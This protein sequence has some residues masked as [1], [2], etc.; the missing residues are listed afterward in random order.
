MDNLVKQRIG[1]FDH[2]QIITTKNVTY[3]SAAPGTEI[4]PVGLWS[5]AAVF[6]DTGEL[7]CV[8]KGTTIRIPARDVLKKTGY[9]VSEITKSFGRL[10]DGKRKG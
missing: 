2:V 7:L 8:Q 9:D 3:L 10:S 1:R 4:K 5:V 6:P